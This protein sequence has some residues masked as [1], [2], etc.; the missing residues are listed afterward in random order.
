[1]GILRGAL[2]SSGEEDTVLDYE[3]DE[4]LDSC[5]QVV[6]STGTTFD[7]LIKTKQELMKLKAIY[8]EA[9]FEQSEL[10]M[11]IR[12]ATCGICGDQINHESYVIEEDDGL[13][14]HERCT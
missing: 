7:Q 2:G 9:K 12:A 6:Q 13:L 11:F 8:K 10:K 1:M 5:E 4:I 14:V 3:E